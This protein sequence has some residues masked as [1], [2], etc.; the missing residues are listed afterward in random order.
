M[1]LPGATEAVE[2]VVRAE[3]PRIIAAL[4]RAAG[5]FDLAED[6]LQEALA[7]AVAHW[8]RSGLPRNPGAWITAV[9]E[10]KL[11]DHSRRARTRREHA[12]ALSRGMTRP[13]ERDD[14]QD[15][16]PPHHPAA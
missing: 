3:T 15:L 1:T 14:Q 2:S 12:Q 10:R 13:P 8:R 11:I 9:A 7:A 4:I 6:A 16:D 5:S